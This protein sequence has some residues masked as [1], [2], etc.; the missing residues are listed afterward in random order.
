MGLDYYKLLGISKNA[1]DDE[2]K[3]AYKKMVRNQRST[4]AF[5]TLT[6]SIGPEVAS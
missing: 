2:V 3:K 6:L 4:V 5:D 1:S